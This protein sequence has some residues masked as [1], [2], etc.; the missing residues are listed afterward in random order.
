MSIDHVM[1][2]SV[3]SA[4]WQDYRASNTAM[5]VFYAT[6]PVS[7]LPIR[8]IPEELPTELLPEPNYETGTYGFYGCGKGKI[9]AAFVKSKI[10]NLLFVT[11][12]AGTNAEYKDRYFIT[13]WYRIFKT[14][15]VKKIHIRYTS[16]YSCLDE[17]VCLA[18]RADTVRFVS[19]A[20]AFEVTPELLKSWN[21]NARLTKQTRII[22]D[23][24]QTTAVLE[25][26][27]AKPDITADYITETERLWPHTNDEREDEADEEEEA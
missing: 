9:R 17:D 13:G 10:R 15:D 1:N 27:Q 21:Y 18:L 2:I 25:H 8:E 14:A 16:E 5:I 6:D 12:Y 11:K 3:E 22:L 26:L 20:D 23:E 24:E 4:S 19:I 7:E